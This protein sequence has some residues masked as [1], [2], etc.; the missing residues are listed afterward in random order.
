MNSVAM[1]KLNLTKPNNNVEYNHC[2]STIRTKRDS[3]YDQMMVLL[4]LG[5]TNPNGIFFHWLALF[6]KNLVLH[7]LWSWF[8]IIFYLHSPVSKLYLINV[9]A[10][11]K[12]GVE[13]TKSRL[14]STLKWISVCVFPLATDNNSYITKQI[15]DIGVIIL[16]FY[17]SFHDQYCL[18]RIKEKFHWVQLNDQP[19]RAS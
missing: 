14:F 4:N 7:H 10:V 18:R 6:V 17:F 11:K 9:T 19:L 2:I 15:R 5:E 1:S 8:H 12:D 13:F 3:T 16:M